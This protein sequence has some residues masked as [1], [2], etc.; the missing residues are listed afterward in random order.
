MSSVIG[1]REPLFWSNTKPSKTGCLLWVGCLHEA[2]RPY[3]KF[4]RGKERR[5][6]RIAWTLKNGPI[7]KG[8]HVLHR[9]DTPQCV[10]VKHLFLGTH[11]QNMADRKAKGRYVGLRGSEN[12]NSW[13]DSGTV[14][15][16]RALAKTGQSASSLARAFGVSPSQTKRI[17]KNQTWR[18]L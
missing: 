11:Q 13:L 15:A 9:C 17:I 5:A 10:N 4:G 12:G 14:I 3:G 2:A 16:I 18:N 7:K 1:D 8:L 6:H